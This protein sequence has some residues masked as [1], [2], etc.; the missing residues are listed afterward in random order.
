ML[1]VGRPQ[2]ELPVSDLDRILVSTNCP[3]CGARITAPYAQ[4]RTVGIF[5]CGCGTVVDADMHSVATQAVIGL[6]DEAGDPVP[7][8][9]RAGVTEMDA[10]SI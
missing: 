2:T 8:L 10:P 7:V 3:T 4:I 5:A 6:A 1:T 9:A